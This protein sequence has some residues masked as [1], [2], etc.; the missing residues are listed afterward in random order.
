MLSAQSWSMN[1]RSHSQLKKKTEK[2]WATTRGDSRR[3]WRPCRLLGRMFLAE[4][5][6]GLTVVRRKIV[7]TCAQQLIKTK[8][9]AKL[10]WSRRLKN[11]YQGKLKKWFRG[12]LS[13][14]FRKWILDFVYLS[15]VWLES[16]QLSYWRKTMA[17]V[18]FVCVHKTGKKAIM[19][20]Q[21][22][23]QSLCSKPTKM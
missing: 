7:P 5:W 22:F 11:F 4:S 18:S 21:H 9:S 12:C 8:F 19:N 3:A 20:R 6:V 14:Y 17:F 10:I 15:H 23:F 16:L 1:W 2:V 13:N